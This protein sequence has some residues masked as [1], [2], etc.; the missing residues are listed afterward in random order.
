LVDAQGVHPEW[1]VMSAVSVLG[2]GVVKAGRYLNELI[3]TQYSM[4]I[5]GRAPVVGQRVVAIKS[6]RSWKRPDID[7]AIEKT[8]LPSVA[9]KLSATFP[10]IQESNAV[11]RRKRFMELLLPPVSAEG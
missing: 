4:M 1:F 2:Q 8:L 9:N 10:D 3:V 7:A 5:F 11:I 6:A